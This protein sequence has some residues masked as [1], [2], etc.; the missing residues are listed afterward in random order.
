MDLPTYTKIWRI[1]KRLYKLYDFRLPVPLPLVQ[2][3]VVVGVFVPWVVL[4]QV[5]GVPFE[6][7]WHVLYIVPPLF[8]PWVATRPVV[9]N[10]KL[11]ELLLSQARYLTEPRT[12]CRLAPAREP[13]EIVIV[14]QI[15]RRTAPSPR[16]VRGRGREVKRERPA[17]HP[18]G[19]PRP[20]PGAEPRPAGV[21]AESR[22]AGATP[23][24]PG[25]GVRTAEPVRAAAL[26][27]SSVARRPAGASGASA[28][29]S[30]P[31]TASPH[32]PSAPRSGAS[33]TWDRAATPRT[34]PE[35]EPAPRQ[36]SR[37]PPSRHPGPRR[38]A[39]ASAGD[40][41]KAPPRGDPRGDPRGEPHAR[42]GQRPT[43]TGPSWP[44]APLGRWPEPSQRPERE[45]P[46]RSS[47]FLSAPVAESPVAESPVAE[48]PEPRPPATG[49]GDRPAHGA[50]PAEQR[51]PGERR[52]PRERRP[53]PRG[54]GQLREAFREDE[55]RRESRPRQEPVP[56][57]GPEGTQRPGGPPPA[58]GRTD[59]PSSPPS[60]PTPPSSPSPPPPSP[61]SPPSRSAREAPAAEPAQKRP[62][63]PTA[64]SASSSTPPPAPPAPPAPS[65]PSA[66]PPPSRS[67]PPPSAPPPPAPSTPSEST[68]SSSSPR[69][70]APA[71]HTG[72]RPAPSRETSTPASPPRGMPSPPRE[73]A[74]PQP[75]PPP[76]RQTERSSPQPERPTRR[77]EWREPPRRPEGPTRGR[78]PGDE[79]DAYRPR[80]P[81]TTASEGPSPVRPAPADSAPTRAP[82][83][84]PAPA[85]SAPA[86][87]A[88]AADPAGPAGPGPAAPASADPA[89][90]SS[91]PAAGTPTADRTGRGRHAQPGGLQRLVGALAGRRDSSPEDA[92][93]EALATVGS[94]FLGARRVVVLG[95]TGGAGQTVTALMFGHTLAQHRSDSCVAV[96]LNPGVGSLA[97]RSRTETP[98]T[99]TSL[100]ARAEEIDGYLA[101]RAYTSQSSSRLE[102]LASDDEPTL[103]QTL[104]DQDYATAVSI[105]D[106]YY[107][108]AV[109]DPAAT[110]VARLLPFADQLVLVAPASADAPQ[111]V[112][113][114]FDW[115][116]EHHY[117]DLRAS[118][119]TVINGVS[120]RS[121]GD[122]QQTEHVATDR[123]RAV[124]Q[125]PWDDHLGFESGQP[126]EPEP[127]RPPVRDA[128]LGLAG[129][130]AKGFAAVPPRYHQEAPQ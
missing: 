116:D 23:T 16:P 40:G 34:H 117:G 25:P 123:C 121:L 100:L 5:I 106:R 54:P 84:G 97:R 128:Y 13:A 63:Q 38:E 49:E 57:R 62:A 39:P 65:A 95:C 51:D 89:H 42:P 109:L 9:E 31:T 76:S 27:A 86:D 24:R 8:A 22:A 124:V 59:A 35:R 46:L 2:I 125:V 67:T 104:S 17:G 52:G 6:S 115:L 53:D 14:G 28:W 91:P 58:E 77:P 94:S 20:R 71:P 48:S 119:V 126:T 80:P 101:M 114:T 18:A 129:A 68:P 21:L 70:P 26:P 44:D 11:T 130:V 3:G 79:A 1:E 113:M 36:P 29:A 19:R 55:L 118:A 72:S 90:A 96:D 10:K 66:P 107:K 127:L 47:F 50:D 30:A 85:S 112:A 74:R 87:A 82:F 98:E 61:P 75:P 93:R 64:P 45:R 105:L 110:V 56:T 41:D 83:A 33:T 69:P 43:T 60:P 108:V 73:S 7:P 122:A 81:R 111:A 37:Q 32:P 15:W 120:K 78:P 102:V 99:L 4:L 88:D 12:W 92:L 103:L